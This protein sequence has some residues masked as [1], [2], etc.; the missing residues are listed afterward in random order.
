MPSLLAD[1]QGY[2][3]HRAEVQMARLLDGP[4]GSD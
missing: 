3:I 2:E 1:E 4:R